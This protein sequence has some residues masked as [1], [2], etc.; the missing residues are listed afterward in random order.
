MVSKRFTLNRGERYRNFRKECPQLEQQI[1]QYH[2]ASYLGI[3][4]IQ[5]SGMRKKLTQL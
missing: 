5:L 4:P 1:L 3:T 2:V